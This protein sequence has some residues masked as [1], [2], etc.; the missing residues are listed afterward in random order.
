MFVVAFGYDFWKF[1]RVINFS[2]AKDGVYEPEIIL[3]LIFA[4]SRNLC[5]QIIYLEC[6]SVDMALF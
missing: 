4:V 6:L 5:S 1:F 3:R 2:S